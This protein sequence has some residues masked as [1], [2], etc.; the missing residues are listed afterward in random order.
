MTCA[1]RCLNE[2]DR[3]DRLFPGK[4]RFVGF[5]DFCGGPLAPVAD[6]AAPIAYVVRNGWVCAERLGHF[7]REARLRDSLVAGRAPVDNVHSRQPDLIDVGTVVGEQPFCVWTS[8]SKTQVGALV[9]FPLAAK[10][11]EG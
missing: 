7:I 2:A 8:L 6:S 1:A 4:C 11:L 9:L 3:Q 10:V 5:S